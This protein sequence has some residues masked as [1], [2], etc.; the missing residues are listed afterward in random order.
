MIIRQA[1]T[2]H[3]KKLTEEIIS[4]KDKPNRIWDYVNKLKGKNTKKSRNVILYDEK[5]D[6]LS[7]VEAEKSLVEVWRG[8]SHHTSP[9]C[10]STTQFFL[11]FS[12]LKLSASKDGV[13]SLHRG[14][15]PALYL[16]P[17]PPALLPQILESIWQGDLRP[18]ENRR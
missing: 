17:L 2:T 12:Y 7:K 14:T 1:I 4:S 15:G 16:A 5:G 13:H 11:H 9:V 18:K 3:E 8:S 10:H 6:Q